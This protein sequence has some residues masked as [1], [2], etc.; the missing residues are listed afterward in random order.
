MRDKQR[1]EGCHDAPMFGWA[2]LGTVLQELIIPDGAQAVA[3][4]FKVA[5]H[6]I[7]QAI[8]DSTRESVNLSCLY[9]DDPQ[10]ASAASKL[11]AI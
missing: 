2:G 5:A 9:H 1:V 4:A 6:N 7:P 11:G 8:A 10:R 3:Q